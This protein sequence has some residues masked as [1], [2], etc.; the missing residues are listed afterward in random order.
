MTLKGNLTEFEINAKEYAVAYDLDNRMSKV[1]VDGNEVEY[2][3][4]AM[5]RRVF[6]E[7][8]N[9]TKALIWW[10]N[11]ENAEHKHTATQTVI[12]NDIFEHP[13]RLNAVIARAVD[14]SKFDI[15]WF[16]KNYLDHVYAV[17]DDSGDILEHY[18]YT[19]F[20]EV[21]IFDG[22]GK[23]QQTTQIDNDILWNTRRLDEVSG[24]YLYKYR[25]YSAE[26]G[27][28][29]GRDPIE[30]DGGM[31]LYAFVGND[32]V[33]RW[34]R[35]GNY[36]SGTYT[37]GDGSTGN[38]YY[39]RS[40]GQSAGYNPGALRVAL[41]ANLS[42]GPLD[43]DLIDHLLDGNGND[44]TTEASRVKFN[45]N[46]IFLS[47][48]FKPYIDK[49]CNGSSEENLNN[50]AINGLDSGFALLGKINIKLSG[51]VKC[52]IENGQSRW[53]FD[54]SY[55]IKDEAIDFNYFTGNGA[56][57]EIR[58][59]LATVIGGIPM[60]TVGLID[61]YTAKFTGQVNWTKE[62]SCN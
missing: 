3:Y 48:A 36:W 10:G 8:S 58:R 43:D 54:G 4:D 56:F 62:G 44:Y 15:Q 1:E 2:R 51:T 53:V 32:P 35:L 59:D 55:T 19:A 16:H 24:F 23:I 18:R 22:L 21:T 7:E 12:Q 38:H 33:G 47:E 26:L 52:Q 31:N 13:S 46:E 17:S 14:G 42:G 57:S 11:S 9:N 45:R 30:E 20:G 39:E 50:V 6:R 27:R 37:N 34:D 5:G 61:E 40:T 60:R 25:H 29:L 41:K 28:W 49:I